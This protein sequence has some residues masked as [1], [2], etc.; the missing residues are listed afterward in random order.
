MSFDIIALLSTAVALFCPLVIVGFG[1]MFSERSGV[2]NLGLEGIM[3]FGAMFGC[4][5]LQGF[6]QKVG[7]VDTCIV[8]GFEQL[9]VLLAI[10]VSVVTGLVF[11]LLLSFAAIKLKAN[12]TITGTALN[13]L[14]P[15][16]GMIFIYAIQSNTNTTVLIPTWVRIGVNLVTVSEFHRFFFSNFFLTTPIILL[17]IVVLS[18]FLYKTRLGLR[19]RACGENPQAADSVGVNVAKMRY[20]GVSISGC[21]AGIGGLAY[22]IATASGFQA[23]V[24]VAGYGFLAL[25]VMIFGNWK[26]LGIIIAGL[27]FTILRVLPPYLPSIPG[28]QE[29]GQI[30]AIIPYVATIIVLIIFSKRSRAPKAE[31]IPYDKSTR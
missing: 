3:L 22:V 21:L 28:I 1:G 17:L 24:G 10:L 29:S 12:Q 31:G 4:L 19:L 6:N 13:L 23:D 18:I 14:A 8:P 20:L 9:I 25:A 30:Y 2:I 15:A 5:T 7:G 27:F 16:F 26:P 11:S